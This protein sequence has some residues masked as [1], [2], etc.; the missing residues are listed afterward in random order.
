MT[1]VELKNFIKRVYQQLGTMVTAGEITA[2]EKRD[3]GKEI[4]ISRLNKESI[5]D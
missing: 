4:V 3:L 5:E 1:P 2:D